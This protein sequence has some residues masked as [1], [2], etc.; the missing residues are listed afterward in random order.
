M[1][2]GRSGTGKTTI[3]TSTGSALVLDINEDGTGVATTGFVKSITSFQEFKVTCS[4]LKE[5][6]DE[7][8]FDTLVIDTIGKLADLSLEQITGGKKAQI[9]DYG[10][11]KRNMEA[12]IN[13][14]K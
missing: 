2:Y 5:V 8:N 10:E 11:N 6:H 13:Y 12:V 9:Q 7:I 4:K 1:F 14:I 3:A